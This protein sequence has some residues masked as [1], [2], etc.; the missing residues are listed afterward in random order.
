[1]TRHHRMPFGAQIDGN[2]TR[3]RL[4]APGASRV[5]LELDQTPDGRRIRLSRDPAG[6]H[7]ARVDG[8]GAGARLHRGESVRVCG[9]VA[10]K[11]GHGSLG[12]LPR[13]RPVQESLY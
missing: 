13:V 4:W 8:V 5:E 9:N 1:M 12:R 7:E 2:A 10:R 3:F 11:C 6:W